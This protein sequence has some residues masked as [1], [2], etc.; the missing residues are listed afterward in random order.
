MPLPLLYVH[1]LQCVQCV[2]IFMHK[3]LLNLKSGAR[4][5]TLLTHHSDKEC[6]EGVNTVGLVHVPHGRKDVQAYRENEAEPAGDGID[7]DL[8]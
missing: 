2:Q 3:V 1:I 6:D 4:E 8:G 7:G 5:P